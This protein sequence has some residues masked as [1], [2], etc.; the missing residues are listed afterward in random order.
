LVKQKTALQVSAV[1]LC[2][3]FETYTTMPIS[4]SVK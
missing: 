1:F 2:R 3:V 4:H